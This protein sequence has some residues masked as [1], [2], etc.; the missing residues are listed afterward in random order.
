MAYSPACT[1]FNGESI[2]PVWECLLG[3]GS[4][5]RNCQATNVALLH[6]LF[7]FV[8]L[9]YL[10]SNHNFVHAVAPDQM[11]SKARH[12]NRVISEMVILSRGPEMIET[13]IER[14]SNGHRTIIER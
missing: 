8:K 11:K 14:S 6:H 13:M 10:K 7:N 1:R 9:G 5:I 4:P 3:V 12:P 2:H